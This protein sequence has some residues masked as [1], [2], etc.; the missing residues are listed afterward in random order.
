MDPFTLTSPRRFR[1]P[2]PP[3]LTSLRYW[4]DYEEVKAMGAREGSARTARQ[5]D[6]AYFYN[7]NFFT[8]WNR[9]LRGVA[10]SRVQRIGDSARLFALANMAT[11]D[12]LITAWDS[13]RYYVFWRPLTAIREGNT[14]GHPWTVG[15][16]MWQPLVNTPNYPDYTSGANALVG[17]MTRTLAK[18]FGSDRG[19]LEVT[20]L[21]PLVTQK[22]RIYT[23]FSEA[24]DDV[25][26]ARIYLGIHFR[27][28]D[29]VA[30]KQGEHVAEHAVEH[31]LLPVDRRDR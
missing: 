24:A 9:A 28:A 12:A 17:A 4:R 29:V 7:D 5:T 25:V 6:L 11:A 23:R 2:P 3:A 14:D 22:T 16:S 18:F 21:N 19:L 27:F 20:S 8:Q 31:F 13:K 15:D 26:D 1:A 30:R 10:E